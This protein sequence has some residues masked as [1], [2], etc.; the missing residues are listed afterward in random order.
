METGMETTAEE[1]E[2]EL[3]NLLLHPSALSPTMKTLHPTLPCLRTQTFLS[4]L[5]SYLKI[6]Q[7]L[8]PRKLSL[9]SLNVSSR[10]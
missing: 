2:E 8:Q 4:F 9:R 1:E 5:Q 10:I 6:L 3:L 7:F